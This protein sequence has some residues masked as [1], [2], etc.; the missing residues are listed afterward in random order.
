M[1]EQNFGVRR[2]SNKVLTGQ[3]PKKR[4][5]NSYGL[6]KRRPRSVKQ[7]RSLSDKGL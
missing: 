6:K 3:Q 4:Q 2:R 7:R 1:A 5:Q